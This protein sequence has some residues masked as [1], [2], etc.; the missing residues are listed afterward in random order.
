MKHE[1]GREGRASPV[2]VRGELEQR[3]WGRSV[4]VSERDRWQPGR[5]ATGGQVTMAWKFHCELP[6]DTEEGNGGRLVGS[7]NQIPERWTCSGPC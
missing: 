7:R 3:P 1:G 4:P 2:G 5:A 6:L